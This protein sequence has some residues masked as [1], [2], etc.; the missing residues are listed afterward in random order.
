MEVTFCFGIHGLYES[1][2]C[3]LT[4]FV[5][6]SLLQKPTKPTKMKG[7]VQ[8]PPYCLSPSIAG[9]YTCALRN[10]RLSALPLSTKPPIYLKIRR[11]PPVFALSLTASGHSC[12]VNLRIHVCPHTPPEYEGTDGMGVTAKVNSTTPASQNT[13]TPLQGWGGGV[14]GLYSLGLMINFHDHEVLVVPVK[15][16]N[17]KRYASTRHCPLKGFL[18]AALPTSQSRPP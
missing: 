10:R 11:I 7:G 1:V 12:A 6:L 9:G 15:F 13:T 14:P 8:R 4:S 16:A 17:G 18:V 2:V 3:S 5:S